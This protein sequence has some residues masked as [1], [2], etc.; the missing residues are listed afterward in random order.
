MKC[1]F[2]GSWDW[3]A[4]RDHVNAH[5]IHTWT[6]APMV[7]SWWLIWTLKPSL[8]SW[9]AEKICDKGKVGLND[10]KERKRKRLSP[11]LSL[12]ECELADEMPILCLWDWI[13]NRESWRSWV[14]AHRHIWTETAMVPWWWLMWTL[15]PTL[16]SLQRIERWER[17]GKEVRQKEKRQGHSHLSFHSE[18]VNWQ[19]KCSLLGM[20]DW[21]ARL[22]ARW[23]N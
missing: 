17:Q 22:G 21:I 14:E 3:I 1:S 19:I 18:G 12:G 7:S 4:W 6:E 2:L 11:Q 8:Q 5:K 13:W 15:W 20:W 10:R 23:R 9:M 16:Q